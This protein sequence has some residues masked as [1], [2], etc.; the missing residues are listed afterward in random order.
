MLCEDNNAKILG[1]KDVIVK[2]VES[3]EKKYILILNYH[4]GNTDAQNAER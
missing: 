4:A 3:D 1:L 2:K